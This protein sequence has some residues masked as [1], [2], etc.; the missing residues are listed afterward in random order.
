MPVTLTLTVTN[1]SQAPVVLTFPTEQRF[2]VV[3]R[4]AAG[5]DVWRWATGRMFAQM[6]GRETLPPSGTLVY[7][8]RVETQLAPG[9]HTATGA[10][11]AQEGGLSASVAL[12]VASR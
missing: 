9:A 12:R 2:D 8:A 5:R 4:D 1:R 6:I 10:V 7:T 11:T 3:V